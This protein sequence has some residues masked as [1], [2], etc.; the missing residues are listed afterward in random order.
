MRNR[1]FLK[2]VF[3]GLLTLA[4][5]PGLAGA[6]SQGQDLTGVLASSAAERATAVSGPI[7]LITPASHD[8]GRV[9]V[10]GSTGNFN[11]TV[12]NTGGAALHISSVT[13]SGPGFSGVLGSLTVPAGGSTTLSSAYTPSGSGPALDAVGVLSDATNGTFSILLQGT[14]NNAPSYSPALAANYTAPAF[15]PFSLT[16]SATDPEG[17]ALSWSIASVPALPVGA[18]FDGTTGT[19]NWTP[20]SADGG[21]YAVSVTVSDGLASALG[22]FALHVT[23]TN[24]PPVANPGNSYSGVTGVPLAFNGSASSDP[25]A[26]QTLTYAWNFG[27]GGSGTGATPSHTY[28]APG[29]YLASLIVTDNGTPALSSP[30]ASAPVTIVNFVPITL[31]RSSWVTG[32][33]LYVGVIGL[34]IFGI[35]CYVRPLTEIDPTSIQISTTYPNAGTVSSVSVSASFPRTGIIITDINKNLFSDLDFLVW[36]WQIKPLVSHVPNNTVI[37][38]VFT[39]VTLAD[40]VPIRGTIDATVKNSIGIGAGTISSA[41]NPNP[42]KPE[43]TIHYAVHGTG[44]VAIRVFSVGGQLVRSLREDFATPGAYEVRWNGKD[45]GGRTAPSGIYFV[46]VQQGAESST[47]RVVL[48]R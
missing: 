5:V 16:A 38:L 11:F 9:N 31:V 14:A 24:H 13:H 44:A 34:N 21:N 7:I 42:F 3:L 18:T 28:A 6:S 35:E 36:S 8:F 23:V 33:N 17:D 29:N 10:G 25:D 26:G 32:N 43:T 12:S 47:T 4:F 46:S 40:H 45:D 15:L 39:G 1:A 41:A 19:L 30:Q 22:S 27:D 20:G 2:V 37:T 48:A